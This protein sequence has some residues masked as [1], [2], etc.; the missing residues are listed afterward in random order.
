MVPRL[1]PFLAIVLI[2]F[3]RGYAENPACP[4]SVEKQ[5]LTEADT[6]RTWDAL[7][8][9]FAQYKK[10]DDGAIAEGYSESVARILVDHWNTLP[11]LAELATKDHDFL[12]FVERHVDAT[13]DE[14]DLQ[15]IKAEAK[16]QCP[17][18]L[19]KICDDLSKEADSA[20]KEAA[21]VR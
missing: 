15:K 13:N 17:S 14:Q 8:K 5:A 20:L 10:C 19:R 3:G 4:V 16:T 11:Q 7:Y 18:G 12:R 9:S 6:L 2:A 1:S 21:S